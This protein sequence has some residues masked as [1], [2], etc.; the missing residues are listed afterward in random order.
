MTKLELTVSSA[1][2]E[3]LSL[4]DE[5][6]QALRVQPGVHVSSLLSDETEFKNLNA[7]IHQLYDDRNRGSSL[8]T[9]NLVFSAPNTPTAAPAADRT[10]IE[11]VFRSPIRPIHTSGELCISCFVHMLKGKGN[12][13]HLTALEYA[14]EHRELLK[15]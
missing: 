12:V 5:S 7:A 11:G 3:C 15:Q 1:S 10:P 9:L 4:S 8:Q 2:L 13:I 6:L 14:R